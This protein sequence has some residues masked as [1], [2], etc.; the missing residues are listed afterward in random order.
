MIANH[1]RRY[2]P[3]IA[4]IEVFNP[5]AGDS[6][7]LG[8]F[9]TDASGDTWLVSCYHVLVRPSAAAAPDLEPIFQSDFGV[10]REVAHTSLTMRDPVLDVAA[11]KLLV[12][13]R[14]RVLGIGAMNGTIPAAVGMRV[15]KSGPSTGVTEG[16]V[17][18]VDA[19]RITID[20][21]DA[22]PANYDMNERGDSGAPW[23]DLKTH[24]L[25]AM[26]ALGSP[27]GV[28][29]AVAIPIDDILA[30]LGLT[31]LP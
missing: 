19:K 25:V 7:A 30:R 2:R 28:D 5:G 10:G 15:V 13:A 21:P 31:L 16:I 14:S 20:I 1:V 12:P 23:L 27:S 22:F 24:S 6:G 9:G 8:F 11:A 4:G 18:K 17:S 29:Q 26:H 3:L